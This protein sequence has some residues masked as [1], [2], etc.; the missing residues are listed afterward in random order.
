[1]VKNGATTSYVSRN[2]NELNLS[3]NPMILKRETTDTKSDIIR[4]IPLREIARE[5]K[6]QR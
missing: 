1:M 5:Y 3:G 4:R 6:V 2:F